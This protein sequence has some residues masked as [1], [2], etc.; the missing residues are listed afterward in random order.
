MASKADNKYLTQQNPE[1][2]ATERRGY[3]QSQ[4]EKSNK[5][6]YTFETDGDTVLNRFMLESGYV[7]DKYN[8]LYSSTETI[9]PSLYGQT[10]KVQCKTRQQDTEDN[11]KVA[12]AMLLEQIGQYAVDML[13]FDYV[14]QNC[15]ADYCLP[16]LGVAWVR[17]DPKFS[18]KPV[19]DNDDEEAQAE[20]AIQETLTF[21]GLALDYVTFKDFRCG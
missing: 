4:I 21:E 16:G 10:P 8:I 6:W 12:A 13:D 15:V 1:G 5:R 7:G 11:I 3:W 20:G 9:K 14:M 18:K 19:N 2:A 17:Y